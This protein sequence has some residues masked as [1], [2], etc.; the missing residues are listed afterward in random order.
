MAVLGLP[1]PVA[2][3]VI[4]GSGIDTNVLTWSLVPKAA[5]L[6]QLNNCSNE[7]AAIWVVLDP[8]CVEQLLLDGL[9][10]LTTAHINHS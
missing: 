4:Q 1:D 3:A 9:S 10:S 6:V 7:Q 5:V 8:I 2:I